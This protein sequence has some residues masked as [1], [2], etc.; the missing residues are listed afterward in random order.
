LKSVHGVF[1]ASV[2]LL[3]NKADVVFDPALV[4]VG[5]YSW[6]WLN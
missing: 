1:R 2:A 3:Q 5:W 4:K 6:R